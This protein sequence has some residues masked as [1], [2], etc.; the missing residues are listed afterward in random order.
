MEDSDASPV[1]RLYRG[2]AVMDGDGLFASPGS[3]AMRRGEVV[4]AGAPSDVEPGL[5][6]EPVE[7]IDQPGR[8]LLPGLVNAHTH[9]NL[10][11]IGPRPLEGGSIDCVGMVMANRPTDPSGSAS[12]GADLSRQ[13][14]VLTVGD[15]VEADLDKKNASLRGVNFVEFFGLAG[16]TLAQ[17]KFRMDE[18]VAAA[19]KNDATLMCSGLQP[20][21]PYSTG[22]EIYRQASESGLPISTH[23][24]ETPEELGFVAQ[25]EGPFRD[26]LERMGKWDPIIAVDYSEGL[27]PVDWLARH[28]DRHIL[29]A[30]CN[31]VDDAHIEHLANLGW[32]VAYCPRA[33]EYFGHRDHRYRDMLAAG[34]NVCLGTDSIICHGS[35]SILD[36][37]RLLYQRD[38]TDPALLLRMATVNGAR[39]LEMP[40]DE[41]CFVS[42]SR[43]GLLSIRYDGDASEGPLASIM[44]ST[45][46][47][48]V[49]VLE[50]H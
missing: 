4:A 19:S 1:I 6:G 40:P 8:L 47:L 30:H 13:A 2:G 28:V 22:P 33:S 27:H 41:V 44:R 23:L 32:S 26:L 7:V 10:T 37:M 31:Y 16:D 42:G 34:V 46:T 17:S 39:A 9:L 43:P 12:R 3:V 48:D 29:C 24:A 35:L 5:K 25:A 14:G 36:E 38:R 45:A 11:D 50:A 18:Y 49:N 20:H 21:A 15:I